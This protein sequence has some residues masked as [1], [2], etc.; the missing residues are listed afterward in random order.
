MNLTEVSFRG[1]PIDD[2][3]IL[4][5]LPAD[6]RT[7]LEAENGFVRYTGGLH[8][9]GACREPLWHSLREVMDGST[10]LYRL[11]PDVVDPTDIPFAQDCSGD[12]FLIRGGEVHQ[13]AAEVGE[14]D[15]LDKDLAQFLEDAARDPIENLCMHPLQSFDQEGGT[16]S[17]GQLLLAYP[18]FCTGKSGGTASIKAV[19]ALE[20]IV[21]HAE[22]AK[23]IA[24]SED[25]DD[26]MFQ[27]AP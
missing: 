20:V 17:P 15:P 24:E 13:L 18:P 6:L 12:Q 16:L 25:G 1:P 26:L 8:V 5:E 2:P 22:F 19:N 7:F 11:Y 14:I 10:S 21:C 3:E 27:F 4:E 23:R 9:R